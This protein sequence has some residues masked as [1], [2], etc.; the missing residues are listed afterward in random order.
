MKQTNLILAAGVLCLAMTPR[1]VLAENQRA[2][3]VLKPPKIIVTTS[4]LYGQSDYRNVEEVGKETPPTTARI[5]YKDWTVGTMYSSAQ[6][7][8]QYGESS[9]EITTY[10]AKDFNEDWSMQVY[11]TAGLSGESSDATGLMIRRKFQWPNK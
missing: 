7:A 10:V 9:A 11:G 2:K 5:K 1:P 6:P 4:H 8:F 3:F